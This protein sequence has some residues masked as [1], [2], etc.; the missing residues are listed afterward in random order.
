MLVI[1]PFKGIVYN[2]DKV[3]ELSKVVAPPYDVIS[4]E[5]KELYYSLHPYN[6]VRV[7]LGKDIP[8]DTAENNKYTRAARYFREWLTQGIL[9]REDTSSIYVYSQEYLI[10]KRKIRRKGFVA[11]MKL[12]EF[13]SGVIFPHEKIFRK[14]QEDRLKLLQSCRANFSPI[15]S[16]FSDPHCQIDRLLDIG[17]PLFKFEDLEGVR[18]ELFAI[19]DKESINLICSLMRDKK[20][21]IAD[22]HHRYLTALKFRE[23]F[24]M[25]PS[26]PPGIDYTMMYFLNTESGS[27]TILPVHRLIKG[28]SP[29]KLLKLETRLNELF[30]KK[31]LKDYSAPLWEVVDKILYE[32]GEKEPTFCMYTEKGKCFILIPKS[33]YSFKETVRSAILDEILK[34]IFDQRSLKDGKY[35]NFIP[36]TQEAIKRVEKG[37]FQLAFL[38]PP[39][40]VHEIKKIA[41]SGKCM[42]PKSTYFYPKLFSGLV[43]RDLQDAI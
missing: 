31:I 34:Y 42:P 10:Q 29:D 12:E 43:M 26:A 35:I 40:T 23:K 9:K 1:R 18:H 2:R 13:D 22:G 33:E 41:F 38:L 15:F 11:L 32:R 30:L 17:E 25:D 28:L 20:L 36:S 3:G 24:K 6:I 4:P 27:V 8:G 39:T 16:L 14:P 19:R 37:E 21:L 7:I 5:K